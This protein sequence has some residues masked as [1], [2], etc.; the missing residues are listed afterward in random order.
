MRR[1]SA[2]FIS[3]SLIII[4]SLG[5]VIA[6]DT[7]LIPL[8]MKIGLEVSGPATYF[9]EKGNLNAEGYFA[10]DINEK[11]SALLGAGYLNYKYSQY[12]YDYLNNGMF[13]RAGAEF[14]LLKPQKAMG[15]YWGGLGIHYGLSRFNSEVTTFTY[16]DKYWGSKTSSIVNKTNW[17]HFIEFTPGVR[18]E[19]IKHISIG[20]TISLRMLLYAGG[21]TDVRPI[22][23]P[24]FGNGTK[25][26]STGINYFIVWN[27]PYK[28][29]TVII[30]KEE[31][32]EDIEDTD[33]NAVTP[34]QSQGRSNS[35]IR[36]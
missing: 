24:G 8:K 19:L 35:M 20:W 15:I 32:E 23:F 4:C 9:I 18:A 34:T 12:N 7:L 14:N 36:N 10:I 27:I 11:V 31:P 16:K 21:G 17:G 25:T 28:K 6:Q 26:V 1:I 22:Y 29:K 2:Y 13:L 33:P 30:K 5:Q 3:L